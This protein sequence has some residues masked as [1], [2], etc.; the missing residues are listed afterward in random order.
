M[1]SQFEDYV[2]LLTRNKICKNYDEAL[3]SIMSN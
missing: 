1:W 2:K 3:L